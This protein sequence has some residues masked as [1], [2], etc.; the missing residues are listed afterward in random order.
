M[1]CLCVHEQGQ[2][3]EQEQEQEQ[4]VQEH[5]HEHEPE[6]G[7]RVWSHKQNSSDM[8]KSISTCRAYRSRAHADVCLC[9]M[10]APCYVYACS[11]WCISDCTSA[12]Q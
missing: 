7:T 4:V 10:Y 1:P 11:I 5:E 12:I 8:M 3:Q 6:Q 9:F 2:E